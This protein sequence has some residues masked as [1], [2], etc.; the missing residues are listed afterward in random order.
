[1]MDFWIMAQ[2]YIKPSTPHGGIWA[3]YAAIFFLPLLKIFKN[4]SFHAVLH[5]IVRKSV[6]NIHFTEQFYV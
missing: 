5:K 4:L 3:V 6:A 2:S 1:A